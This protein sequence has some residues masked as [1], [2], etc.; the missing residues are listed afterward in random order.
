MM[1]IEVQFQFA[2]FAAITVKR[3]HL[4]MEIIG[5]T[6]FVVKNQY[7]FLFF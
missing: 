4:C 5:I 6:F 2:L 7:S 3:L 1:Y